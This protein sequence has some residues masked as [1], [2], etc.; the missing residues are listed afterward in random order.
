MSLSAAF[1]IGRTALAVGQIGVQVA[2]NNMANAATP[3]YTRQL[4]RLTPIR[5]TTAG[6][7]IGAG[8]MI[9]SIQRQLDAAVEARLRS[10][11]ADDAFAQLQ[12]RVYSQIED[13]LGELGD[14]DLS[15]QLSSFFTAWSE[16]ANQTRS[17]TSVVQKGAQLAGF[18]RRLRSDLTD[19]R[20]QLDR[21]LG[22]TVARANQLLGQIA[23]FNRQVSQAEVGGNVANSLRDQ[24]DSAVRELATYMDISVVDRGREGVDVLAGSTPVVLGANARGLTVRTDTDGRST[25]VS[26]AVAGDGTRLDVRS[27]QI[28]AILSQRTSAVDDVIGRLDSLVSQVIFE[29]NKLHSTGTNAS[30]LRDAAGTLTMSSADRALALNDAGNAAM[31]GL[32]FH[33]ANGGFV[34][35]VRNAATGAT[36]S[37]RIN[38]DLDGIDHA[39]AASTADDTTAEDVRAAL[40]AVPGLSASFTADGRLRVTA[41]EG[42]DFSFADDTSGVLACLGVNSYFTGVNASDIA[43]RSDL[44]SDSSLLTTGRMVDGTFVENGT[45][46]ELAGLQGRALASLSGRTVSDTWRDTVQTVGG[47]AASASSRAQAASVVRDSLESQRAAVSGVSIDEESVNLLEYQRQYQAGARLITVA[48]DMAKTLMELL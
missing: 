37:V 4:A 11:T 10:A 23:D 1:D 44:L 47:N 41:A 43:V 34:V 2:G 5:G 42:F 32:P 27:G 20:S 12:S 38:I 3:G 19:Q 48:Q 33:P 24:R 17:S 14:N 6:L 21:E 7:G 30:G 39:G 29:V 9:S 15:S 28:G 18:V 36:Q 16:R 46:L 8:V 13:T 45:A 40:A 25:Q 26:V 35:N 31:T 22:A